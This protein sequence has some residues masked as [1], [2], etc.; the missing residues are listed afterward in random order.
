METEWVENGR[1]DQKAASNKQSYF[2]ANLPD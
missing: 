2:K 1:G